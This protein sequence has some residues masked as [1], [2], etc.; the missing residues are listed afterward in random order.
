MIKE[1]NW[2]ILIDEYWGFFTYKLCTY[3]TLDKRDISKQKR[4]KRIK[5]VKQRRLKQIHCHNLIGQLIAISAV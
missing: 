2:D 5:K 1:T 3:H 4:N